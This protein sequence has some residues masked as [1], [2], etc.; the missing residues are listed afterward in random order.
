MNV[1]PCLADR[2]KRY[3]FVYSRHVYAVRAI[4]SLFELAENYG[5][6]L[7]EA[8]RM[9]KFREGGFAKFMHVDDEFH[10]MMIDSYELDDEVAQRMD[11][12]PLVMLLASRV[13]SNK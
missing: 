11:R 1:T 8:S 4:R 13:R 2:T 7:H 12:Y 5:A 3:L 10:G 6:T 9:I